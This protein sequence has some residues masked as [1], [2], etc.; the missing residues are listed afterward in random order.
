M[1][2]PSRMSPLT[3]MFIGIFGVGAVAIASTAAVIVYGLN[4][5]DR[6]AEG[7]MSFADD[8]V[9]GAIEN[10][11][12]WLEALPPALKDV[13]HDRRAPEYVKQLEVEA[14]FV[15]GEARQPGRP[16]VT[17]TNKGDGIVTLLA[18]RVVALTS[19]GLP[20][21]EWTEV[22]ATPLAIEGE[23][24]GPLLP[25]N[26]RHAII[27][28]HGGRVSE[29]AEGLVAAVEIADVRV[30]VEPADPPTT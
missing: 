8:V 12:A 9:D 23:W 17:V 29:V 2:A 5:L 20:V 26:R 10:L 11:P 21:R 28:G 1:Q 24:R 14:R 30:F 3:A 4:V 15:G 6:R 25:G 19:D 16:V 7:L 18:V 27:G 22:I 13:L